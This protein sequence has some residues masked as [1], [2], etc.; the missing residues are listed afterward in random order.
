MQFRKIEDVYSKNYEK[1]NI[2]LCRKNAKLFIFKANGVYS[3]LCPLTLLLSVV[4]AWLDVAPVAYC[5][6]QPSCSTS[7]HC[8]HTCGTL[9]VSTLPSS[10]E[11]VVLKG[12]E[13]ALTEKD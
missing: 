10:L 9:T 8:S 1:Q 5:K 2:T 4:E 12:E 3:C 11:A 7:E 13:M 6:V